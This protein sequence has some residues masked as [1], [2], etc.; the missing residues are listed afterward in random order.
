MKSDD[1]LLLF[2]DFTQTEFSGSILNHTRARPPSEST[3]A[4]FVCL[5]FFLYFESMPILFSV[6]ISVLA[7][8]V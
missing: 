7:S 1:L 5:F 4:F 3:L 6:M 8:A 2:A